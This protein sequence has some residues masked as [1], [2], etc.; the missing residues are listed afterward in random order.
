MKREKEGRREEEGVREKIR[1][2]NLPCLHP[3]RT[4][5]NPLM[6]SFGNARTVING[7]SSRF[8]KYLELHFTLNGLVVGAR[9]SE[10][11]LEKSRVVSQ[12]RCVCVCVC[13]CV[14]ARAC[15]RACE[16]V[17]TCSYI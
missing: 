3:M 5:V 11:L 15:V 12:A 16:C 2:T 8:G 1:D 14:C 7:N 4:Q 10:Y 6:E 17:T 13:V 9:L